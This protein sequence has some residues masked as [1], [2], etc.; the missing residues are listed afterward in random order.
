MQRLIARISLLLLVPLSLSASTSIDADP[1]ANGTFVAPIPNV[2]FT[3]VDEVLQT[4]IDPDGTVVKLSTTREIARDGQGRVYK[5]ARLLRPIAESGTRPV[6]VMETYDPRTKTY[7]LIYPRSKTYWEG[8]LDRTPTL[9]AQEYLYGLPMRDGLPLYRSSQEEKLG[10]RSLLGM[11][12]HGIREVHTFKD[13]AGKINE[14]LD[15]YWYSDDL[16]LS[17]VAEDKAPNG[18]TLKVAITHINLA[19]P[20]PALFQLPTGYRQ[21]DRPEE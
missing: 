18:S 5:I 8:D 19:E 10:T 3:A 4:R 11:S 2:P 9:L 1:R 16:Q 20:D 7:I 17:M 12:V 21:V 14:R 15:E 6:Y 13:G